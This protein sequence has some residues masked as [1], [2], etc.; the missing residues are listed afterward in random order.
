MSPFFFAWSDRRAGI[1]DRCGVDRRI[2]T[3]DMRCPVFCD[4][5]ERGD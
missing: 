2:G 1:F 5:G 4:R 3:L